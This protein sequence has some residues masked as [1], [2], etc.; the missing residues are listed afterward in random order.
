MPSNIQS[1]GAR[2]IC[3]LVMAA[4]AAADRRAPESP[5]RQVSLFRA[6]YV[7]RG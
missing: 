5:G 3:D 1:T 2:K 4:P 7:F 6:F